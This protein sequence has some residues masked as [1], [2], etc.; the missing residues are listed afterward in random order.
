VAAAAMMG[1]PSGVKAQFGGGMGPGS[2]HADTQI[3]FG[4]TD[5]ADQGGPGMGGMGGSSMHVSDYGKKSWPCYPAGQ[6]AGSKDFHPP[7]GCGETGKST[8]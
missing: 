4:S 6:W 1:L 2:G 7:P 3:P 8:R 5:D